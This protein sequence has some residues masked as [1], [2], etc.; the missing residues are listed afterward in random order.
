VSLFESSYI[1]SYSSIFARGGQGSSFGELALLY[2]T[3]RAATVRADTISVLYALDRATFRFTLAKSSSNRSAEIIVALKNVPILKDLTDEQFMKVA[4]SV[5]VIK[6]KKGAFV[7]IRFSI[8]STPLNQ[9]ISTTFASGQ[10]NRFSAK[11][12]RGRYFT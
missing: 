8:L 6:L 4:D 10:M 9:F 11:E 3:P 7:F 1:H 5:E 2:N 12:K